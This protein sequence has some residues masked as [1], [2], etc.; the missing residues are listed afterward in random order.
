MFHLLPVSTGKNLLSLNFQLKGIRAG[1]KAPVWSSV[2]FHLGRNIN[3]HSP[4]KKVS[5][6]R[7]DNVELTRHSIKG[8]R[9]AGSATEWRVQAKTCE[10]FFSTENTQILM[11]PTLL[12]TFVTKLNVSHLVSKTLIRP[13]LATKI[14]CSPVLFPLG[15]RYYKK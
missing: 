9:S 6:Q 2:A 10:K 3:N 14:P 1:C 11:F 5:T 15:K 12:Q 13:M 8:T 7:F 4:W